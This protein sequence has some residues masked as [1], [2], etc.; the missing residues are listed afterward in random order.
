MYGYSTLVNPSSWWIS[1]LFP[2]LTVMDT[3]GLRFA[4]RFLSECD[5]SSPRYTS[6]R[7]TAGS[8]GNVTALRF[9]C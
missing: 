6:S 3:A 1:G 2:L 7:G 9:S 5:F 4:G 8:H